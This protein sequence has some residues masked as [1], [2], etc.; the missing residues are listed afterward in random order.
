MIHD[1]Q[2]AALIPIIRKQN[3]SAKIF[4]RAHIDLAHAEHKILKF[5]IQ[6]TSGAS[7]S[8]FHMPEFVKPTGNLPVILRPSIDPLAEKN[9]EM[10]PEEMRQVLDRYGIPWP[11][12]R[13]VITQIL[14]FDRWKDP[15]P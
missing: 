4:W 9:R 11:T 3:P 8:L 7:V 2:L 14:R 13:F 1:P 5:L 10:S 12:D 6:Y 15:A